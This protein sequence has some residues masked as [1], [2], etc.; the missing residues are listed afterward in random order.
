MVSR[1][2]E[3]VKE[4]DMQLIFTVI[5]LMLM[6]AITGAVIVA[7]SLLFIDWMEGSSIEDAP[8]NPAQSLPLID[9]D[10]N[11]NYVSEVINLTNKERAAVGLPPLIPVDVLME[12][13]Q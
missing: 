3:F 1:N 6:S 4:A 5:I 10:D 8:P 7:G 13:A 9:P 11:G 2:R 12:V